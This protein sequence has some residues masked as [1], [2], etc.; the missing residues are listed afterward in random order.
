M[1]AMGETDLRASVLKM[2]AVCWGDERIP[3]EEGEQ[4]KTEHN[5]DIWVV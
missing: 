2:L 4:D 1:V 5:L 3:S